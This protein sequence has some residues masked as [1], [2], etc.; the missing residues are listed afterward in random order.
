MDVA[1]K[2]VWPQQAGW[3][4]AKKRLSFLTPH[5]LADMTTADDLNDAMRMAAPK[6][7]KPQLRERLS[8]EEFKKLKKEVLA[9]SGSD[10]LVSATEISNT[11]LIRQALAL[12]AKYEEVKHSGAVVDILA[13]APAQ[14]RL[15]YVQAV[16]TLFK[17]FKIPDEG[18]DVHII[19][20]DSLTSAMHTEPLLPFKPHS[21]N[22]SAPNT[23]FISPETGCFSACGTGGTTITQ[24]M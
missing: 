13:A 18:S 15:G 7:K 12:I 4:S 10:A 24:K 16:L 23:S 2:A 5:A 3:Q 1:I 8:E 14:T 21:R 22:R 11:K 19:P 17:D 20:S 9:A 6:G